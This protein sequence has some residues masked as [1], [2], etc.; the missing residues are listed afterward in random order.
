MEIIIDTIGRTDLK[1]KNQLTKIDD[2]CFD[3]LNNNG[4]FIES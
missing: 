4:K 1:N 2:D 3:K